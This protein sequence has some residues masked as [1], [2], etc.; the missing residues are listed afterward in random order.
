MSLSVG[1]IGGIGGFSSIKPLNYALANQSGVSETYQKSI[2]TN[3][4]V[5]LVNPVQYPNARTEETGNVS[6]FAR[7]RQAGSE[8]NDI[9]SRYAGSPVGYSANRE[10][11][12]YDMVG[13]AFDAIA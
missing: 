10:A 5:D 7:A 4:R 12:S 1:A 6:S 13:S 11:T 3:N 9:A 8:Y 2:Q